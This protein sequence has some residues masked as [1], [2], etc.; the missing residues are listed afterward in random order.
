MD[1]NNNYTNETNTTKL[2]GKE[3]FRMLKIYLPIYNFFAILGF[4]MNIFSLSLFLI[5][6]N[7]RIRRNFLLIV[8]NISDILF[9]LTFLR[10][11]N[12]S[13]S[14]SSDVITC[15]LYNIAL[16]LFMI[17]SNYLIMCIYI[18]RFISV[19]FPFKYDILLSKC[20]LSF[21]VVF[22]IIL[23]I[24]IVSFPIYHK[25]I[26]PFKMK[27]DFCDNL[28]SSDKNY[29]FSI[30]ILLLFFTTISAI[31]HIY[32]IKLAIK[33]FRKIQPKLN[34]ESI[35]IKAVS[36]SALFCFM[37]LLINFTGLSLSIVP[38]IIYFPNYR[39]H[40]YFIGVLLLACGLPCNP[41]IFIFG[42]KDM[43]NAAYDALKRIFFFTQRVQCFKE[44]PI[45][46]MK[47]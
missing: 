17:L 16:F 14:F 5:Y 39:R 12:N 38:T 31:I 13:F 45:E 2:E 18:E 36:R 21:M 10:I 44:R 29:Y 30:F 11:D 40:P 1:N 27:Y 41:L 7:L 9:G 22:G 23:D 33:H 8:L 24:I 3:Y 26:I 34:K 35:Q 19:R 20:K 46:L 4:I 37:A 42:N 32:I 15:I 43:K 47:L 25:H 28:F 6:N